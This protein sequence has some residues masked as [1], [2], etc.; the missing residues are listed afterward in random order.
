MNVQTNGQSM[1]LQ[2]S[3]KDLSS[4]TVRSSQCCLQIIKKLEQF[5][6]GNDS[7]DSSVMVR[8]VAAK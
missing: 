1:D 5:K 2:K 3:Q 7:T 4:S 8:N 6:N